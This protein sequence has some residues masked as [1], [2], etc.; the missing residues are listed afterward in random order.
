M[1]CF[2]LTIFYYFCRMQIQTIFSRAILTIFSITALFFASC[3]SQ[4][5][6]DYSEIRKI[7]KALLDSKTTNKDSM[8]IRLF[9][10]Y[11]MFAEKYPKDK[12]ANEFLFKAGELANGLGIYDRALAIFLDIE[13][14]HKDFQ[15][16]PECLFLAAFIE[17]NQLGNIETA[18]EYYSRFIKEYPKHPLCK[19]AEVCIQNL[20]KTPEELIKEFEAKNAGKY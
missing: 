8:A 17:E 6:Q 10:Q 7:E 3:Q 13:K 2:L 5:D 1:P 16:A 4:R 9:D 15:K 11:Q 20:G 18:K 19:D 12:S 14:N